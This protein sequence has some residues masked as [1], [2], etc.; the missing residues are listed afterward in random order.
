M[1]P[2]RASPTFV[3]FSAKAR[4]SKLGGLRDHTGKRNA[5]V[6]AKAAERAARLADIIIPL[7]D[8]GATLEAIAN[9]LNKAGVVTA[10]GG[11]WHASQVQ[12]TLK[13]LAS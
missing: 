12:R 6:Q 10:R 7:R 5:A 1:P 4:G 11:T 3:R 9:K 13:R 8:N 2:L